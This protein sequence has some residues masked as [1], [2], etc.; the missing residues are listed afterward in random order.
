MCHPWNEHG[1]ILKERLFGLTG[2]EGNHGEDVKEYYFYL[3]NTPTHSYMRFLLRLRSVQSN[4]GPSNAIRTLSNRVRLCS[5]CVPDQFESM[6]GSQ[7]ISHEQNLVSGDWGQRR[8]NERLHQSSACCQ[9][10]VVL[11]RVPLISP[12]AIKGYGVMSS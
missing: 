9:W 10:S 12:R 5:L 3:D 6:A 1:P 7:E 2:Y 8:R 4:S 11:C